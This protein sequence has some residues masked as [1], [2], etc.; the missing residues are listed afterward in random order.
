MTH[1]EVFI[2]HDTQMGLRHEAVRVEDAEDGDGRGQEDT[3][4][5]GMR[6]V[7]RQSCLQKMAQFKVVQNTKWCSLIEVL[8]VS[9]QY[10]SMLSTKDYN[11]RVTGSL[12]HFV[13]KVFCANLK[14]A[15]FSINS[16]T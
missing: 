16:S 12:R 7:M 3:E 9:D 13:L 10:M 8:E 4:H 1:Q 2:D 14:T 5:L 11:P 15:P 6:S